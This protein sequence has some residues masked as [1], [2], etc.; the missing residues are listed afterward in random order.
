MKPT[1]VCSILSY[2][3]AKRV[4]DLEFHV[5]RNKVIWNLNFTLLN[6]GCLR[7]YRKLGFVCWFVYPLKLFNILTRERERHS[8]VL[9]TNDS[10]PVMS[11]LE[12]NQ[13]TGLDFR[14]CMENPKK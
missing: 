13:L 3:F 11:Y 12:V 9:G 8:S 6:Y 5:I 4:I 1:V 14:I 10:Y 7:Y 2:Y